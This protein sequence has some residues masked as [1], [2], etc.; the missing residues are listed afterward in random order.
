MA[1]GCK[2][3]TAPSTTKAP[4]AAGGKQTVTCPT[5]AELA[6]ALGVDEAA[7]ANDCVAYNESM[8]WL[9]GALIRVPGAAPRLAL[10]SGSPFVR[11]LVY[12]VEPAPIDAIK[13]LVA[14]SADVQLRVRNGR[15]ERKLV[16]L[17]VVG[18]HKPDS[19][20]SEEVIVLLRLGA[21]APPEL[22]WMGP[23]DEVTTTPGGCVNERTVD[24][25]LLFGTRV[26]MFASNRIRK[27]AADCP[28]GMDT[29]ET[30][31]ARPQRLAPGRPVGAAVKAPG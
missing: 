1:A 6:K 14:R 17:G 24:F 11:W 26:E 23:G 7:V 16:R 22:V 27:K 3:R 18:R 8:F 5:R 31:T 21:H 20:D 25:E 29:Q 10:V 2:K 28:G 19:P 12:D 9:A 4:L 30:V 13:Q 15:R